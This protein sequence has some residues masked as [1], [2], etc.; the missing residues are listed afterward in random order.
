MLEFIRLIDDIKQDF[1]NT[2][3]Y[4]EIN[5]SV[6]PSLDLIVY[7]FATTAVSR[8]RYSGLCLMCVWR[9]EVYVFGNRT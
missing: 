8:N 3:S 4:S 2:R 6:Y 5:Y 1:D 9:T 7:T